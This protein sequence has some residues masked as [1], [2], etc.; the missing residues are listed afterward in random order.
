MRVAFYHIVTIF[1]VL[2]SSSCTL[3]PKGIA[4]EGVVWAESY[5]AEENLVRA[6]VAVRNDSDK[7]VTLQSGEISVRIGGQK[8]TTLNLAQSVEIPPVGA[9]EI[10]T[11][12]VMSHDDPATIYVMSRHPI[13]RYMER[14]T[15]DFSL[16]IERAGKVKILSRRGVK[17]GRIDMNF[18]NLLRK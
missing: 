5:G 6:K 13:E 17:G 16:A 18:E 14:I 3:L 10:E 11:Q 4:I 12:W 1:V 9:T 7:S 15:V 8:L 2:L